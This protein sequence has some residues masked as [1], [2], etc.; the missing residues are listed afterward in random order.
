VL[1]DGGD[2]NSRYTKSELKNLVRESD[3]RIFAISIQSHTPVLDKLADESGGHGYQVAKLDELPEA[4]SKLSAE[5]HG[6]YVLGFHPPERPQDGKY[7]AIHVELRQPKREA[8]SH[9][10]WRH[11]YYAPRQ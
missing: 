3:V 6:G 9:V 4:A 1:S 8:G 2:N 7:H 11:G 5:V 10:G